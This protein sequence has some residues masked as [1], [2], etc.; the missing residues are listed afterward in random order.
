MYKFS[1]VIFLD[2]HIRTGKRSR[3]FLQDTVDKEIH[4]CY[5]ILC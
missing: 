4:I 1:S 3:K 5:I 2:E